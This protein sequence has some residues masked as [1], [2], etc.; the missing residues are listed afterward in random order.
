MEDEDW[1]L[2]RE[3]EVETLSGA[4]KEWIQD[5]SEDEG[6]PFVLLNETRLRMETKFCFWSKIKLKRNAETLS[7]FLFIFGLELSEIITS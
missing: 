3:A 6:L 4:L 1:R 7:F 2:L 5:P